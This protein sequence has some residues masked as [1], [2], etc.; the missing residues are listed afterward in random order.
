MVG[1]WDVGSLWRMWA[2]VRVW[3]C[4]C[5]SS[6]YQRNR[7]EGKRACRRPLI[8]KA[9]GMQ[10]AIDWEGKRACRRPLIGKA[11]GHAGGH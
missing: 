2:W 4:V 11:N 3:A 9:N 10:A 8:G 6:G 1:C 5:V 7:K